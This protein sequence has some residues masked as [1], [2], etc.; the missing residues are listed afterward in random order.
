M[1]STIEAPAVTGNASCHGAPAGSDVRVIA[2]L[3]VRG[4]RSIV[5]L[6]YVSG[7]L[8]ALVEEA[9]AQLPQPL[10]ETVVSLA[11]SGETDGETR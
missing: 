9:R 5:D 3:R 1:P 11:R 7:R 2:E 10:L 6:T 4:F 8:C